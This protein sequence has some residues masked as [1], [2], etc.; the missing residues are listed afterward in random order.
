[1]VSSKFLATLCSPDEDGSKTYS[2]ITQRSHQHLPSALSFSGN[3]SLSE[4][5][6]QFPG[7]PAVGSIAFA[8]WMNDKDLWSNP[9]SLRMMHHQRFEIALKRRYRPCSAVMAFGDIGAHF[10]EFS[11]SRSVG[12]GLAIVGRLTDKSW[13]FCINWKD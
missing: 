8:M 11:L 13:L 5:S 10:H 12:Y 3:L 7:T 6:L 2:V 1:M 9:L 4:H